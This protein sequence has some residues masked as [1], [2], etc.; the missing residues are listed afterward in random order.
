M[1]T[2]M[3]KSTS[4]YYTVTM[5]G[6]F[7]SLHFL[8]YKSIAIIYSVFN[9]ACVP[10]LPLVDHKLVDHK[11]TNMLMLYNI[12][13]CK[14]QYMFTMHKQSYRKALQCVHMFEQKLLYCVLYTV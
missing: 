7:A 13:V 4:Y 5:L 14:H 11:R 2:S 12:S 1:A 3:K 6:K 10:L 8:L 9:L